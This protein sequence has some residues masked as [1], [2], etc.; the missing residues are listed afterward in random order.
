MEK[1]LEER[2]EGE[3]DLGVAICAEFPAKCKSSAEVE[4]VLAWDMPIVK[5]GAG[6]RQY[7]RLN[8]V[9]NFILGIFLFV[10]ILIAYSSL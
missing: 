2:T 7:R 4:F 10:H 6:R 8:F 3:V 9:E 5:F 1:N